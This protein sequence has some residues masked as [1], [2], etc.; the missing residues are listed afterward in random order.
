MNTYYSK[1]KIKLLPIG[2]ALILRSKYYYY[3]SYVSVHEY[4]HIDI[5]DLI[6]FLNMST[7]IQL[8]VYPVLMPL[9]VY[10]C[11]FFVIVA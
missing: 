3:L 10:L 7:G 11:H 9:Y 8:F 6:L 2:S 5:Y 1:K 4:I